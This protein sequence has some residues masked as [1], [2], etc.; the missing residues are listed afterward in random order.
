MA[1]W[2]ADIVA[3]RA[4]P[5]NEDVVSGVHD[6]IITELGFCGCGRPEDALR[7]LRDLLAEIG[8]EGDAENRWKR[9]SDAAGGQQKPGM[10][11]FVFY[12]L[13][14]LGL[15]DHGGSVPGWLSD[16]G[17]AWLAFLQSPHAKRYLEGC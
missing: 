14:H 16:R 10:D 17:E 12:Q 2:I 6:Q 4:D 1:D 3:G 15:T 9:I 5:Q 7:F 13:D 11:Y 8:R